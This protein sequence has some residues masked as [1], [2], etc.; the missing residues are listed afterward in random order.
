[1]VVKNQ[2]IEDR[3]ARI[4]EFMKKCKCPVTVAD[5]QKEFHMDPVLIRSDLDRLFELKILHKVLQVGT[6]IRFG[7]MCK[8]KHCA[9]SLYEPQE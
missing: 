9:W 4:L 7:K 6:I 8:S 5:I 2:H 3:R 1:M